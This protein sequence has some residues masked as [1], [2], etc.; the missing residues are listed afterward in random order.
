MTPRVHLLVP[1]AT[2]EQRRMGRTLCGTSSPRWSEASASVTCR[3][4]IRAMPPEQT[5]VA[6]EDAWEALCNLLLGPAVAPYPAITP[7]EWRLMQCRQ[8]GRE[9][10][11]CPCAWC[12]WERRYRGQCEQH[13]LS[14]QFRP[15]RRYA[16]PFGS[17]GAALE[18]LL[19]VRRSAA[20]TRSWQGPLSDRAEQVLRLG[21]EVQ[22]TQRFDREP[23]EIRRV[24]LAIDV[25][26]ALERCFAEA[27]ERRGLPLEACTALV[28]ASIDS[29]E[30]RTPEAM[31]ETTGLT[32][33]A[34]KA[35]LAHARRELA[36]RL[37]ADGLVPEQR[38]ERRAA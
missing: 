37:A 33:R 3:L 36:V 5:P 22:T 25:E 1:D 10:E 9:L 32:V 27:A 28:L 6:L 4:C 7:D 29:G 18:H 26:R 16:C 38:R 11:R 20:G 17:V 19:R 8:Y 31:S 35:L 30:P 34:V 12:D 21:T 2:D 15:H 14:Q 24:D 13:D 23:L